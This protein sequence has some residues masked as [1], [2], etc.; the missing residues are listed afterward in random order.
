LDRHSEKDS[1]MVP[2][3]Y[4][5]EI[6]DNCVPE[7]KCFSKTTIDEH[8]MFFFIIYTLGFRIRENT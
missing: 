4:T 5:A 1:S 3:V 2:L 8:S 6:E 7:S